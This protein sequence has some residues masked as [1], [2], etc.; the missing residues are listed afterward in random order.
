MAGEILYKTKNSTIFGVGLGLGVDNNLL[1]PVIS[2]KAY[3]KIG[4]K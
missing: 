2:G 1:S 4:K 3:W